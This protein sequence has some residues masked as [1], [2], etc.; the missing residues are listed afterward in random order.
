MGRCMLHRLRIRALPAV[1]LVLIAAPATHAST[2]IFSVP[3]M[4]SGGDLIDRGFYLSSYPGTNLGTVTLGYSTFTAGDYTLS[5]TAR[6]G[7]YDGTFVGTDTATVHLPG[8]DTTLATFDFG[9]VSVPMGS[10]VTFTQSL[11]VGPGTAYFDVG[12]GGVPGIVETEG[13]TPPL[14]VLRQYSVG[15]IVTEQTSPVPEPGSLLLVG[16]GLAFLIRRR[17]KH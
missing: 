16:S 6:L 4:G 9:G 5:L 17:R 14:D 15:I 8:I 10:I 1:L 7:A 2:I 13:T 11:L 3:F 12:T